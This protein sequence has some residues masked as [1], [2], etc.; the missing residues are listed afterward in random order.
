MFTGTKL[1]K[2]VRS[3]WPTVPH[4]FP[5]LPCLYPSL[6]HHLTT[7][8]FKIG[9]SFT[10]VSHRVWSRTEASI[11][12]FI[13]PPLLTCASEG[14][15]SLLCYAVTPHEFKRLIFLNFTQKERSKL[16]VYDAGG[17]VSAK[18]SC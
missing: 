2:A 17:A 14:F 11:Y 18:Y 4:H 9:H 3:L 1:I 8:V 15:V 6:V 12:K 10:P 5:L 16:C 13:Q 7:E